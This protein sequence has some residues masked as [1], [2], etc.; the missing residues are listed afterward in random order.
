MNAK[1]ANDVDNLIKLA[2]H[3]EIVKHD[4][5]EIHLKIKPTGISIAL[6]IDLLGLK[7]AINGIIGANVNGRT[8]VVNYDE[9]VIPKELWELLIKSHANPKIQQ[10]VRKELLARMTAKAA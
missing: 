10:L 9:E 6:S 2:G 8:V 1:T 4:P 5:G 3:A 7:A